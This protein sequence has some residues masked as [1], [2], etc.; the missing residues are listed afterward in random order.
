MGTISVIFSRTLR[1]VPMKLS[2]KVEYQLR[3]DIFNHLTNLDQKYYR[4]NRTGD[5]MTRLSSDINMIRDAIGQGILQGFRTIVVLSFSLIVM[6]ITDVQLAIT[7][8]V[9]YIPMVI[10]F[11]IILKAMRKRQK[12]LQEHVSELSNFSQETF[13]GIR[14]IK[15]FSIEN[16]R[17]KNFK[18]L[19]NGLIKKNMVVQATRQS[20]WPFMSFWF[21]IG[22]ISILYLG[23]KRI[24]LGDLSLGT[25]TQF[26]Q[27]L[28][29]M[30]WPLLALSWT[31]SLYQRA[32]VSWSRV[33]EIMESSSSIKTSSQ[34]YKSINNNNIYFR[35][36]SLSID[37]K[38]LLKSISLTIENGKT[39]GITGPTGSGKSLL[40]SLIV[41]LID[42]SE[43][44]IRINDIDIKNLSLSDLRQKIGYAAQEPDLFSKSLSYNIG[45]GLNKYDEGQILYAS[46]IAHLQHDIENFPLKINT[47]LGERGVTLSGGQ[48]QRAS[49]ARAIA[50]KPDILILDDVLAAVD[51]Q[52]EAAILDNLKPIMQSTTTIFISHR[53]SSLQYTDHI[54]VLEE[55]LITQQGT[56]EDLINKPGYYSELN[57]MQKLEQNLEYL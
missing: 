13:S 3:K 46:K 17:N 45:F 42:P 31:S 20:L 56:H 25:I 14:C 22:M 37:E 33:H 53:I 30:Q 29:Y 28:L 9:L 18:I 1:Q 23:G 41:R 7:I 24:I 38:E 2:H 15:G 54:I 40:A 44:E 5:L 6:L 35:N 26:I 39:L 43:G 16:R 8:Y 27:Y 10:I 32:V 19:N 11:F 50:K 4:S 34:T 21:G 57:T 51:T 12:E 48:R 36:V 49:I 52:T 47:I 55:G